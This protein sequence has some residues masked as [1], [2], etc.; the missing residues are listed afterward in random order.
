MK[1]RIEAKLEELESLTRKMDVPESRQRSV[2]WLQ[3]NLAVRN[4]GHKNFQAAKN[5]VEELCAMG[6]R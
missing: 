3:R 2:L 4:S 1:Q 6:V 5:I